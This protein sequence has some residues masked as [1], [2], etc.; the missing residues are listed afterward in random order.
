MCLDLLC[1]FLDYHS[2]TVQMYLR[3]YFQMHLKPAQTFISEMQHICGP[4]HITVAPVACIAYIKMTNE[5]SYLLWPYYV[6]E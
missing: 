2:V 6:F 5:Y 1:M 3:I 4:C